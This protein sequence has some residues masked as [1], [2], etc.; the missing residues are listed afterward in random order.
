MAEFRPRQ[1]GQVITPESNESKA[2]VYYG[3]AK[4]VAEER[5]PATHPIRLGLALNYSV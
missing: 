5:L 4:V 1:K 2:D 3:R